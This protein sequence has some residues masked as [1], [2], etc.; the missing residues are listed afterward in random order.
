MLIQHDGHR[1]L[2]VITL[3]VE[4]STLLTYAWSQGAL[5]LITTVVITPVL[6]TPLLLHPHGRRAGM[7]CILTVASPVTWPLLLLHVL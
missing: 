1:Q 3:H 5:G 7:E 6:M 4:H 2:R